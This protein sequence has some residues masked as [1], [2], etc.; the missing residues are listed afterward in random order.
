ME[1][2][3]E[4]ESAMLILTVAACRAIF[5][6]DAVLNRNGIAAERTREKGSIPIGA[7]VS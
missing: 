2:M 1:G 7:V 3:V 5:R 6:C 4:T